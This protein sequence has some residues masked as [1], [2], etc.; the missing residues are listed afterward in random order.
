MNRVTA[1]GVTTIGAQ[2]FLRCNLTG[3]V[4]FPDTLKI[5]EFEAF[6]NNPRMKHF[7]SYCNE[8]SAPSS[9]MQIGEGAF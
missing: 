7:L 1:M 5:I 3:D 9:L 6:Y 2:A 8:E 4:G